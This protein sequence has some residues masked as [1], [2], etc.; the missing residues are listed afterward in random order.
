MKIAIAGK[1]GTGKTT[2]AAIIIDAFKQHEYRVYALDAD[3]NRHLGPA[4]GFVEEKNIIPIM[5][6]KDL[7][8]KRM[9]VEDTSFAPMFKMNPDVSD[10]PG[11]Y[12]IEKDGVRLLVLGGIA[13][14]GAGCACPENVFM[15]RLLHEVITGRDEVVVADME[16]GIEHLGRA[17]VEAVDMLILVVEPS[18]ASIEVALKAE[19]MAE[20]I[21]L[22]NF[23][24]IANKIRNDKDREFVEKNLEGK[25]ILAFIPYRDSIAEGEREGIEAGGRDKE[26]NDIIERVVEKIVKFPGKGHKARS[27]V[28]E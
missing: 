20:Q 21:N 26:I 25:N 3:P 22:K 15:R 11:A 9:G 5:E 27:P 8:K 23:F 19:D 14:G 13:G 16:A 1:G 10:L 4:L 2:I 7:I 17:T 24:Y 6:M 18:R 28:S 12:A